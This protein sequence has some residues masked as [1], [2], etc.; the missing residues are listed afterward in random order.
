AKAFDRGETIVVV[1]LDPVRN[2]EKQVELQ[3]VGPR[4]VIVAERDATPERTLAVLRCP[5]VSREPPPDAATERPRVARAARVVQQAFPRAR[6]TV[7]DVEEDGRLVVVLAE[8]QGEGA[9]L[10]QT[11]YADGRYLEVHRETMT[12]EYLRSRVKRAPRETPEPP[13]ADRHEP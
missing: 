10:V 8:G 2:V 1:A 4:Y 12:D 6:T 13:G 11:A 3:R 5:D 9:W 7:V